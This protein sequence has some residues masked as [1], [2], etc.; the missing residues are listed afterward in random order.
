MTV[1]ELCDLYLLETEAT[2]KVKPSTLAMDRS[3]I[4][5]HV[6]PLIGN[7]TVRSLLPNDMAKLQAD[8][9]SGRTAKA[10]PPQGR[11]GK[12]TGGRGVA[13][14]TLGMLGTILEYGKR[15]GLTVTNPVRGVKR[16]PDGKQRRFLSLEEIAKLGEAMR[17]PGSEGEN[18]IG[19]AAVR[20]LL[21]T[22]FRRMEALALPW[23]WVDAKFRCIRFE[24]TKS[25]PPSARENPMP[26][27]HR[28][29][30]P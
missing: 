2:G 17:D 23:A 3:R 22:G 20:F 11:G 6:R 25:G 8:I 24:D 1:A 19:I 7:R 15:R 12:T 4:E 27:L 18:T 10:R 29:P 9:T 30:S 14:R 5:Q 26:A 16:F 28:K 13:A 21:L